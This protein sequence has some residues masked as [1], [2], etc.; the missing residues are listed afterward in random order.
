MTHAAQANTRSQGLGTPASH[1]AMNMQSACLCQPPRSWAAHRSSHTAE[2]PALAHCPRPPH[3][4]SPP[5]GRGPGDG[6]PAALPR[7]PMPAI[8]APTVCCMRAS[9]AAATVGGRT[10]STAAGRP[11]RPRPPAAVLSHMVMWLQ[12]NSNALQSLRNARCDRAA[13]ARRRP[14]ASPPA[15]PK[16]HWCALPAYALALSTT[17]CR[18]HLRRG[19]QQATPSVPTATE[20]LSN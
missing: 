14:H 15:L 6:T 13:S 18:G 10:I 19:G 16:Q 8:A 1:R 20:Q 4:M 11:R 7:S 17:T 2:P 9:A 3:G 12:T 5:G